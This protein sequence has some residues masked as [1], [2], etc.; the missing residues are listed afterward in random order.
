[1]RLRKESGRSADLCGIMKIVFKNGKVPFTNHGGLLSMRSIHP[2]KLKNLINNTKVVVVQWGTD[3][4]IPCRNQEQSLD[5]L[6]D[7]LQIGKSGHLSP[8][9]VALVKVDIDRYPN[10]IKT[11]NVPDAFPAVTIF[12]S[13]H[14][15]PFVDTSFGHT[16]EAKNVIHGQKHNIEQYV[17]KTLRSSHLIK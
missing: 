3:R 15:Q 12:K 1:M 2:K 6:H 8:N 4:C 11:F 10:A 17:I 7:V 14:P 5:D 13:G 9:D 16:S